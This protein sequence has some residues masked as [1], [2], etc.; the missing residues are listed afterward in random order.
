MKRNLL[1][2]T[3]LSLLA[4]A[5]LASPVLA[6]TAKINLSQKHLV[7]RGR[8]LVMIGG[9]NDCHT[10][11]YLLKTG[12]VQEALWLTGSTLGWGG[13]WG[14]TYPPNLRLLLSTLTEDQWIKLAR[15]LKARPPMPWF[16]L[17]EMT[18]SD[19]RA[20]GAYIRYAG[21]AGAPAPAYVPPGKKPSTPCVQFPS[22]K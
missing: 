8:Y 7:A 5:V 21:K 17:R 14:T 16:D 9:C 1:A 4:G 3:V 6:G 13:P 11:G 19:L 22:L 20:I 18:D 12:N 15:T 10:P 2:V